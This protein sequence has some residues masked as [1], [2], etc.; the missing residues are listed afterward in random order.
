MGATLRGAVS[1][2]SGTVLCRSTHKL[3]PLGGPIRDLG[4]PK[5]PSPSSSAP[6]P[7]HTRARGLA[8]L[9]A[10]EGRLH[11]GMSPVSAPHPAV[12]MHPGLAAP[13]AS[14]HL[15]LTCVCSCLW[16]P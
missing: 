8:A 3:E 1:S 11:R 5:G 16:H 2:S 7:G 13:A 4:P 14:G 15:S 6:E 10:A 9:P 12:P